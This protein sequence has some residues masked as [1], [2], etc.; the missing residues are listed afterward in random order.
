VCG[1]MSTIGICGMLRLIESNVIAKSGQA[2]EA[3]GDVNTLLLDK[4]G[5]VTI[6]NR[7]ASA[8]IPAPGVTERE[9][10]EAAELAS[11]FDE[12]PEGRSIGMMARSRFGLPIK[13]PKSLNA[14]FIPFSA[15]QRV[16]GIVIDERHILK[17]AGDAIFDY[18]TMKRGVIS[19]QVRDDVDT[20]GRA[21]GT[22]L[23]V[24]EENRILGVIHLMDVIKPDMKQRLAELRKMGIKS[25]MITGDNPMT[26]AAIASEVGVDDYISQ[27]TPEM[28]LTFIRSA[29]ER[30]EKVAMVG[31]GTND[32]PALAQ[33]DVA[34]VMN[35]G[36]QAA[37]EA[38]NMVDLDSDPSKLVV[39]ARIGKQLLITRGALTTFSLTNDL[40][41]YFAILPAILVDIHPGLFHLN[42]M[43]LSDAR[44]AVLAALIYNA[45]ALVVLFPLAFYGVPY[46][47]MNANALLWRRLFVYGLGGVIAPFIGIKLIDM[48]LSAMGL[49]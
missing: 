48:L 21:G 34:L 40:A 22:P 35:A 28:K 45:L 36:T 8:F 47:A 49:G 15:E 10:A 19:Q 44:T 41:K 27:A 20:V 26:A 31:D 11:L 13:N 9:L 39:I 1:L 24:A 37:K 3:S 18:V 25:V 38:G 4:T 46:R 17:G 6:G 33:A 2:V 42:I 43:Q 5:T 14:T 29:Q 30:G 7:Q 32:A 23:V 12:T 16:S